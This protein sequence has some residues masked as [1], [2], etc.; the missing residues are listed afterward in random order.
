M[1]ILIVS[2][3]ADASHQDV[4]ADQYAGASVAAGRQRPL[5]SGKISPARLT[6][7]GATLSEGSHS[8]IWLNVLNNCYYGMSFVKLDSQ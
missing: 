3:A 6:A 1:F 5:W 7:Q 4:S 2:P 8:T